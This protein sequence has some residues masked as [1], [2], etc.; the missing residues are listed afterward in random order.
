MIRT[1]RNVSELGPEPQ[2]PLLQA[3]ASWQPLKRLRVKT[4]QPLSAFPCVLVDA[5][6]GVRGDQL[7]TPPPG[8]QESLDCIQI[9]KGGAVIASVC[10]K[11]PLGGA[12]ASVR[13]IPQGGAVSASVTKIPLG[14]AENS[15]A[16]VVNDRGCLGLAGASSNDAAQLVFDNRSCTGV[17]NCGFDSGDFRDDF[18]AYDEDDV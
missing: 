1:E 9:P 7:L 15:S 2:G 4:H 12:L 14:G 8:E 3:N 17:P 6:P 16:S 11:I 13:K 5:P 18:G 10:R